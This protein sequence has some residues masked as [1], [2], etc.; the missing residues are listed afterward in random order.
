M[1]KDLTTNLDGIVYTPYVLL[2]TMS[3]LNYMGTMFTRQG[4]PT[5][6]L[7][8]KVRSPDDLVTL[9]SAVQ[10]PLEATCTKSIQRKLIFIV[11]IEAYECFENTKNG[12]SVESCIKASKK[13]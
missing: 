6:N 8:V 7:L 11:L 2:Y 5:L 9:R 12:I 1:N 10:A 13:K 4:R 3:T